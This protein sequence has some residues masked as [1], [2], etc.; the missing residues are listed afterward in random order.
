MCFALLSIIF[1]AAMT[2]TFIHR[3]V[4]FAVAGK[5]VSGCSNASDAKMAPM[6]SATS[7]T[8]LHDSLYLYINLSVVLIH[9]VITICLSLPCYVY[10]ALRLLYNV[11]KLVNSLNCVK[12]GTL[13]CPTLPLK[14]P[15]GVKGVNQPYSYP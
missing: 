14:M 4:F 12:Y 1:R 11:P 6:R 3:S 13:V 9:N 2:Y 7:N 15:V 5:V 10:S 8:N